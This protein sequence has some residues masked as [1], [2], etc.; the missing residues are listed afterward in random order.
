MLL[1]WRGRA[2]LTGKQLRLAAEKAGKSFADLQLTLG[3]YTLARRNPF[4]DPAEVEEY[5]AMG[6]SR[7]VIPFKPQ[8]EADQRATLAEYEA[9]LKQFHK[10]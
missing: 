5:V 6:F 2:Q 4:L 7:I 3:S 1:L 8:A 9:Y 10:S